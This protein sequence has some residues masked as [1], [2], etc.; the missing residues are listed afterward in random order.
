MEAKR[1]SILG[2]NQLISASLGGR[3]EVEVFDSKMCEPTA[4][5]MSSCAIFASNAFHNI[6]VII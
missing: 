6:F 5:D 4:S 1:V 2:I 3:R